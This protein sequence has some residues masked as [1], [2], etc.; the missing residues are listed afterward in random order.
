M[1]V[2]R[3]KKKEENI[4]HRE[5]EEREGE[6]N[7][8]E[9]E[10]NGREGERNG[11]EGRKLS[12]KTCPASFARVGEEEGREEEEERRRREK[13]KKRGGA[14]LF[15]TLSRETREKETLFSGVRERGRKRKRVSRVEQQQKSIN[16]H[17]F[18][19]NFQ[20]VWM[21]F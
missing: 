11:R 13:K 12:E 1:L 15:Q 6:R 3:D 18:T 19:T 10:R 9:G 17:Q 8:R 16:Q 21:Y 4:F 7:G 2:A 14:S 5:R 20:T